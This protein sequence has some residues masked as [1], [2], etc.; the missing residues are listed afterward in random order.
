MFFFLLISRNN[1]GGGSALE[2]PPLSVVGVCVWRGKL[3]R[4][5][6]GGGS[7]RWP[8]NT[9]TSTL[10]GISCV[11]GRQPVFWRPLLN[12]FYVL[13]FACGK[14]CYYNILPWVKNRGLIWPQVQKRSCPACGLPKWLHWRHHRGEIKLNLWKAIKL[15]T[16]ACMLLT[17]FPFKNEESLDNFIPQRFHLQLLG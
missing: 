6:S 12:V 4:D 13:A 3:T 2:F 14:V 11:K 17:S 5:G 15:K 9:H 10:S 16:T 7:R 8:R 1:V